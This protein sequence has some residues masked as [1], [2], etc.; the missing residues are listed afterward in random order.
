MII[1]IFLFEFL[2]FKIFSGK[3][4]HHF[5]SC[6]VF[7]CIAVEQRKLFS[8]IS[9]QRTYSFG[10]KTSRYK[11]KRSN[12]QQSQRKPYIFCKH[13]DSGSSKQEKAFQKSPEYKGNPVTS[14]FQVT[15]K[16]GH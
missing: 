13:I 14:H 6:D 9:K 7:L 5:I 11:N 12:Q 2:N 3:C 1:H 15:G 16:P 8:Q 4:A 10:K